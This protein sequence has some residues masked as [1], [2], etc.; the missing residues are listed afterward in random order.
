MKN[1]NLNS[2]FTCKNVQSGFRKCGASI[3]GFS[4]ISK[5]TFGK[6]LVGTAVFFKNLRLLVCDPV[7]K[8]TH[9]EFA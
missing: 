4:F 5:S 7:N 6:L 8:N 9:K 3:L 1:E 2:L